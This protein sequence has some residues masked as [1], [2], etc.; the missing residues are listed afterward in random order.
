[1]TRDQVWDMVNDLIDEKYQEKLCLYIGVKKYED[2]VKDIVDRIEE[3]ADS[4]EEKIQADDDYKN[5][6]DAIA[7]EGDRRCHEMREEGC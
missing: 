2:E 6:E 1:M 3:L 5:S 7:D 4:I